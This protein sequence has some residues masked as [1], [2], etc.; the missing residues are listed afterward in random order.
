MLQRA[1]KFHRFYY[2]LEKGEYVKGVIYFKLN[3]LTQRETEG[4]S[5]HIAVTYL[6]LHK[7]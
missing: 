3:L 4:N 6:Q 5:G 1:V 7:E 2:E